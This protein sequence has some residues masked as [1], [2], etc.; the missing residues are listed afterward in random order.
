M[1]ITQVNRKLSAQQKSC[2]DQQ[3]LY[4]TGPLLMLAPVSIVCAAA[5]PSRR[6][7]NLPRSSVRGRQIGNSQRCRSATQTWEPR[8]GRHRLRVL[9]ARFLG[10]LRTVIVGEDATPPQQLGQGP[11]LGNDA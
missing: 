2:V 10:E 3:R 8:S 4:R 5:P 11:L 7:A 9:G 1:T 6:L